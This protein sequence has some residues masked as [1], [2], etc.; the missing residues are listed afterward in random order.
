MA[1]YFHIVEL[2]DGQWRCRYGLEEFDTH[3]SL[4]QA[5]EHMRVVAAAQA[6]ATIFAHYRGGRSQEVGEVWPPAPGCA[7]GLSEDKIS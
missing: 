6:P 3:P 5:L 1:R 7:F 2:E 4:E